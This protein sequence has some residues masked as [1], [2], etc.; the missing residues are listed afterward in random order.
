M[1]KLKKFFING[2]IRTVLSLFYAVLFKIQSFKI[3]ESSNSKKLDP[4]EINITNDAASFNYHNYSDD[5]PMHNDKNCGGETISNKNSLHESDSSDESNFSDQ[6]IS[7]T[8]GINKSHEDEFKNFYMHSE[9]KYLRK[10]E[11]IS[12]T[13][14]R[15]KSNF[16][17][18]F[19]KLRN[20]KKKKA[21]LLICFILAY[22]S[23]NNYLIYSSYNKSTESDSFESSS[24][25]KDYE[26]SNEI[27]QESYFYSFNSILSGFKQILKIFFYDLN[28][29][30]Q[31]FESNFTNSSLKILID[32]QDLDAAGLVLDKS[33][34]GRILLNDEYFDEDYIGYLNDTK[35]NHTVRLKQLRPCVLAK[36]NPYDKE[37]MQFVQKENS[38]KCNPKQNWIYIE[39]GRHTFLLKY[40]AL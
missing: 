20:F 16:V 21:V 38:L 33:D 24:F 12:I 28:D 34:L 23:F 19:L 5:D 29:P 35:S 1:K 18:N 10:V 6:D 2:L 7:F 26:N 37:I 36:L 39:N 31:R 27:N 25:S 9:T 15:S 22:I 14:T 11:H 3:S 8:N 4:I 17:F 40:L 30:N 13:S 32:P